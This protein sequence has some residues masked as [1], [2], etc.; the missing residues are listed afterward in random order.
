MNLGEIINL[1]FQKNIHLKT[2]KIKID[3]YSMTPAQR[4]KKEMKRS[5]SIIRRYIAP[6]L[7]AIAFITGKGA[8]LG[9]G[10]FMCPH[11]ELGLCCKNYEIMDGYKLGKDCKF[12]ISRIKSSL[13]F[14]LFSAFSMCYE[15]EY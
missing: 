13:F 10:V 15:F 9:E 4:Q 12:V 1:G 5:K 7:F 11:A 14:F 2:L 8:F 3:H 6:I